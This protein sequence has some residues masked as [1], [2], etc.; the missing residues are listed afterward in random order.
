MRGLNLVIVMLAMGSGACLRSTEYRCSTNAECGA[1]GTCETV[2]Y[3]SFADGQCPSGERF[4][5]SAGELAN[6]CTGSTGTDGGLIDSPIDSPMTIDAA[7]DAPITV[8]CPGNYATITGGQGTHRYRLIGGAANWNQQRDF[9]VATTASAYLAV[10]DDLGE[11]QALATLAAVSRFWV[12]ITDSAVEN[13]W[14]TTK[15]GA[16]ATFLPWVT[17]APDDQNPGE[18]CV[19]VV[20]ATSQINDERCNTQYVAVCECEP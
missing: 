3:C 19:E 12:G 17:G 10:P 9:C 1:G 7:I 8:G 16:P 13:T 5:P 11:L 15:A 2:G 18:D 20:T 14:L 6:Q 4:G